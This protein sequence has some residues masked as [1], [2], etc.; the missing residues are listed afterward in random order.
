[1]KKGVKIG[2]AA[3][4]VAAVIGISA[5]SASKGDS[6][7]AVRIEPVVK[8]DLTSS[9]NAS[10]WVRPNRR[11]DV[12]GDIMGR[13]VN[14]NV[15][16]GQNVR[17]GDVMLRIDPTQYEAAVARAEAAGATSVA[18]VPVPFPTPLN[19]SDPTTTRLRKMAVPPPASPVYQSARCIAS[20]PRVNK[21]V[22]Y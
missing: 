8:R 16:E 14:L 3:G 18:G 21:S 22:L 1:M 7:V 2:I 15:R 19:S 9:V 12:Q 13:I 4:V 6:G 5:F 17:K 20:L 11:V 10:G